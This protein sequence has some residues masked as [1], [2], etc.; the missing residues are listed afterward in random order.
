MFAEAH[1]AAAEALQSLLELIR[2]RLVEMD[3]I[4]VR[5]TVDQDLATIDPPQMGHTTGSAAGNCD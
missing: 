1:L 5:P 4:V 3:Q 2:P